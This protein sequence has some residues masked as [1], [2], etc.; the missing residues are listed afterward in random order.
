MTSK[1]KRHAR[2]IAGSI[3]GP[4]AGVGVG[5]VAT[6][7]GESEAIVAGRIRVEIWVHKK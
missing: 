2:R 6:N 5:L 1:T 4:G 7:F 3:L